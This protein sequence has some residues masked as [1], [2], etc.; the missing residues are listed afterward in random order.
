MTSAVAQSVASTL[1]SGNLTE[2]AV[3]V[4]QAAGARNEHGEWVPGTATETTIRVVTAPVTGEERDQLPEGLR[5]KNVRKFWTSHPAD[6]IRAGQADGDVVRHG[7]NEY[8][9]V[10]VDDWGSFRELTTVQPESE[11]A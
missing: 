1:R 3:I 2:S 11:A 10:M 5:E 6:A 8:R 4:R 9:V 7:G